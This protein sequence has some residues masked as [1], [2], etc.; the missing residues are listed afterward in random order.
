MGKFKWVMRNYLTFRQSARARQ[1][2]SN[3]MMRQEETCLQLMSKQIKTLDMQ[4]LI[5][6]IKLILVAKKLVLKKR[7]LSISEIMVLIKTI[8]STL[9][10]FLLDKTSITAYRL[11]LFKIQKKIWIMQICLAFC[12]KSKDQMVSNIRSLIRISKEFL[13]IV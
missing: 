2:T 6:G 9:I 3:R 10:L 1:M 5:N 12:Q 8:L 11:E 7:N 4:Q 13:M